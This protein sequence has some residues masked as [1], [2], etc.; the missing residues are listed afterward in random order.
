M[1]AVGDRGMKEEDGRRRKQ[2]L[3]EEN[4]ERRWKRRRMGGELGRNMMRRERD[5]TDKR[6][7]KRYLEVNN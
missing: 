5:L 6:K 4:G 3:D 1:G 7:K 2:K